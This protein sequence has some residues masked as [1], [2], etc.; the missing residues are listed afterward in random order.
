MSSSCKEF[1]SFIDNSGKKKCENQIVVFVFR[2]WA[3]KVFNPGIERSN[4]NLLHIPV[5]SELST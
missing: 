3:R 5:V 1:H 2:H 4:G